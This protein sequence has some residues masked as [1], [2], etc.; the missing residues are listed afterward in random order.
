MLFS[1]IFW[2]C[3]IILLC[4]LINKFIIKARFLNGAYIY[5]MFLVV[6]LST[7]I[8]LVADFSRDARAI[9]A[10]LGAAL[11]TSGIAVYFGFKFRKKNPFSFPSILWTKKETIS[12]EEKIISQEKAGLPAWAQTNNDDEPADKGKV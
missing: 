7:Q 3:V 12:K 6:G 1:L 5:I 8:F 11:L 2:M 4:E 10:S 9:G